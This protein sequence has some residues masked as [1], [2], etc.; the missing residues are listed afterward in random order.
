MKVIEQFIKCRNSVNGG[1]PVHDY[2]TEMELWQAAN[3]MYLMLRDIVND[4][5]LSSSLSAMASHFK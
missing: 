2:M 1:T 3:E 5:P 4:H